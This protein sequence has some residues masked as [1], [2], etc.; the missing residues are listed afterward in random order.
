MF[1]S[2]P[3][4]G[5]LIAPFDTVFSSLLHCVFPLRLFAFASGGFIY[6]IYAG[7]WLFLS[8]YL[9]TVY[10]LLYALILDTM[11][12]VPIRE[13]SFSFPAHIWS[14]LVQRALVPLRTQYTVQLHGWLRTYT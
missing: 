2:L 9:L 1:F 10:L 14:V 7:R 13:I 5:W 8:I 3:S 12:D 4:T 6:T 11:E